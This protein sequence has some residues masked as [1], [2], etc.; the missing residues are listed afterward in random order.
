MYFPRDISEVG[1]FLHTLENCT[2]TEQ[3][4]I[5]DDVLLRLKNLSEPISSDLYN[6]LL[7]YRML[8]TKRREHGL[9]RENEVL[10]KEL[11]K[12]FEKYS[13]VESLLNCIAPDA[14]SYKGVYVFILSHPRNNA[15][16]NFEILSR[17]NYIDKMTRDVIFNVPGYKRANGSGNVVNEQ[18]AN[19]Q[20]IF[21]ENLFIE[22]VQKLEDESN[23][24]FV[25]QDKCELLV[26]A[27]GSD[28]KYDFDT[29]QRLDLSFLEK[30]RGIDP[31]KLVIA[32][33]NE[34][35]IDSDKTNKLDLGNVVNQVLGELIVQDIPQ[36]VKT[37]IA[38]AKR[39][40]FERA[41]LREELSKVANLQNLDIRSLTFEDFAT[42]LT[43]QNGGRQANYNQFIKEEA[44]IVIFIFDSTVGEITEEEFN[45]AYKSLMENKRPNIFVFVKKRRSL[46]SLNPSSKQLRNIKTSVFDYNKEYYIEYNDY[47]DLRYLFRD[48][49]DKYFKERMESCNK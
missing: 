3:I 38:G 32:L 25:Y 20:L 39:L 45:I 36:T 41:L 29:L 12:Q 35:R 30:K 11:E 37:F 7:Q 6:T 18:D 14:K 9:Q 40:E 28:G 48:S 1:T 49:M 13:Q 21:D 22:I 27:E 15:T 19:L 47:M 23:G 34:V 26:V 17:M 8:L 16:A 5:I 31:V 44:D 42:S 24:K 46:F 4:E 33:A 10:K 43:G 2:L